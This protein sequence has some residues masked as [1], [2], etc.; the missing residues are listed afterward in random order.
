MKSGFALIV[1][2]HLQVIQNCDE[3]FEAG[4]VGSLTVTEG[5]GERHGYDSS[6]LLVEPGLDNFEALEEL[7]LNQGL[8]KI[9]NNGIGKSNKNGMCKC[10]TCEFRRIL[11]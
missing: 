4:G 7:L 9:A 11:Y 8:N 1:S 3:L 5:R 2:L 10:R 6:V